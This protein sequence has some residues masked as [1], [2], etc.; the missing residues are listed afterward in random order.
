M[1]VI[2]CKSFLEDLKNV[3]AFAGSEKLLFITVSLK[4]KDLRNEVIGW[5]L[6]CVQ[7]SVSLGNPVLLDKL[8]EG[9]MIVL[10]S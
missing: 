9:Y 4:L 8:W 3:P 5:P 2:R 7:S 6:I 1:S 10:R